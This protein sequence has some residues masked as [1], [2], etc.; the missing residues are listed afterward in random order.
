MRVCLVADHSL[1]DEHL[2]TRSHLAIAIV[3][4]SAGSLRAEIA[5][6]WTTPNNTMV[7]V[8]AGGS[9]QFQAVGN[10]SIFFDAMLVVDTSG[11][12]NTNT[13]QTA[14]NGGTRRGDW[15]L[16]GAEGLVDALANDI[17]L[18]LVDFDLDSLLTMPLAPLG[19]P[20]ALPSHRQAM[21]TALRAL[22]RV[23]GTDF[24]QAIDFTAEYLANV[25]GGGSSKHIVVVSDGDS[26]STEARMATMNA[27]ARGIDS[28]NAV[29]LPGADAVL[30]REIATLGHG[31][32]VDGTNLGALVDGFKSILD[33]A[34]TL[35]ELDVILPDG[36][37][38]ENVNVAAGGAFGVQGIIRQG[39]NVFRARATSSLGHVAFADLNV[40]GVGVPE[41]SSLLLMLLLIMVSGCPRR[42]SRRR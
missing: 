17:R 34:E 24:A 27:I 37:I 14:P 7:A 36:S 15:A 2:M 20:D 25:P 22:D 28:V 35:A 5:P 11:S 42:V 40:I 39:N 8:P 6:S 19:P 13:N 1:N 26:P 9:V 4:I 3:L 30:L 16:A 38:R 21:K 41:P 33:N 23:G 32:Y 12:M 10:V 31:V 29:G 18:G